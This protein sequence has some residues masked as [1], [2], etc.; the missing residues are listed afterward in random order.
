[1]KKLIVILAIPFILL[2]CKTKESIID[3]RTA[4]CTLELRSISIKVKSNTLDTVALDNYYTVNTSINDTI[5]AAHTLI[6]NNGFY[7]VLSDNYTNKMR[8]KTYQFRFIGIIGSNIVV[9]E[10][11]TVSA[12]CCHISKV[13]GKSEVFID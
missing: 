7:S 2:S 9:D 10:P 13:S 5:F 11:F 8:N 4:I 12:D 1:M 3:C 6:D